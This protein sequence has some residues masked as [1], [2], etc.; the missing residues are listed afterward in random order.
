M[1]GYATQNCRRRCRFKKKKKKN[2]GRSLAPS[3]QPELAGFGRRMCV[4]VEHGC[5]WLHLCYACMYMDGWIDVRITAVFVCMRLG[6]TYWT[7]VRSV[8]RRRWRFRLLCLV[9]RLRAHPRLYVLPGLAGC[10]CRVCTI[11]CLLD[12][13]YLRWTV[14]HVALIHLS[15]ILSVCHSSQEHNHHHICAEP[16]S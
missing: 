5:A 14:S 6:P 15:S 10:S 8:A 9:R 2:S 4:Q 3:E 11:R 1:D 12:A 7:P 16:C 13:Y